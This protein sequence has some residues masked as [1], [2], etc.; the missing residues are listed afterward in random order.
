MNKEIKAWYEEAKKKCQRLDNLL[1]DK[2]ISQEDYFEEMADIALY[3]IQA[4]DFDLPA[5]DCEETK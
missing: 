3:Y 5:F 2:Q 4:C 1:Y